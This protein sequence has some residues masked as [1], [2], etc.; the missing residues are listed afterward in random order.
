MPRKSQPDT[1]DDQNDRGR[2]IGTESDILC[3]YIREIGD[4]ELLSAEEEGEL[5]RQ[6]DKN[7]SPEKQR[8]IK[9]NLRL[10]VLIAR[11]YRNKGFSLPDLIQEGNLGLFTAVERFDPER[12][13][14]FSTYAVW[15]IR[16]AILRAIADNADTVRKPVHTVEDIKRFNS[17][18]QM[19]WIKFK[20][21]PTT[22]EIAEVMQIKVKKA[23]K[24]REA[25][26][27]IVSLD[28]QVSGGKNEDLHNLIKDEN[29]IPADDLIDSNN[30]A[31]LIN[32]LFKYLTPRER[33]VIS[34][35]YGLDSGE[36][37]TLKEIGYEIGVTRERIRQIQMKA[38]GKMRGH[39]KEEE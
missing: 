8:F 37:A 28:A 24:I 17:V 36:E 13:V 34:M 6:I 22:E 3:R 10:V 39:I 14:K 2:H 15:W 38:L 20:R 9:A 32:D 7:D 11:K 29:I 33:E 1:I 31:R 27:D 30:T 12:G 18:K 35:R 23:E 25:A 16:H 19:L 5:A 26:Q 21:T 4:I